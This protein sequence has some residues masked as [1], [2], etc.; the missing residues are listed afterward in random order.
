MASG[1]KFVTALAIGCC[2]EQGL[3]GFSSRVKEIIDIE[4]PHVSDDMTIHHLLSHTSG[5]YDYL[6][7]EIIEDFDN[8]HLEIPWYMLDTPTDYLPLFKNGS[9][10]FKPGERFSYSNGG[11]I[12]LGII[13]ESVTGK[14]Y[15]DFVQENVLHR[16]ALTDSGFYAMNALPHNTAH[17]Y[18]PPEPGRPDLDQNGEWKTNIYNLPIRGASDGGMYTTAV[19]VATLWT[20]FFDGSIVD[21]TIAGAFTEEHSEISPVVSYG[22]GVY[23]VKKHGERN[24]CLL[25]CDAGVGFYSKYYRNTGHILTILSN[26]TDGEAGLRKAILPEVD[27]YVKVH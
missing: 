7:E 9:S 19:D 26:I 5:M 11:Y 20:A 27:A 6:D 14:K 15:R 12:L 17:G 22:Y 21:T 24:F 18:L 2:V 8:L 1:S 16:A 10:K 13:I 4:L 23:I 3:F 25:G